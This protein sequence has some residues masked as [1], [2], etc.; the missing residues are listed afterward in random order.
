MNAS[1]LRYANKTNKAGLST[2]QKTRVKFYQKNVVS[3]SK[4]KFD[5]IGAYNFSIFEF[6]E[7]KNLLKYFK[8]VFNSLA[9]PGTFFFDVAG[10]AG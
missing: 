8:T 1:V 9:N 3:P 5:L 2:N 6:H 4:E 10:G 7:R